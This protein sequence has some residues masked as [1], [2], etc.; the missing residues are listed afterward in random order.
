[1]KKK[2]K[3]KIALECWKNERGSY[4]G[5]VSLNGEP[6]RFA[7]LS[8]EGTIKTLKNNTEWLCEGLIKEM[9]KKKNE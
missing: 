7:N 6:F 1:M 4:D 2:L 3:V 8:E 9:E 5:F